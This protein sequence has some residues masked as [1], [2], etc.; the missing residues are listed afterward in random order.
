[1]S[2]DTSCKLLEDLKGFHKEKFRTINLMREMW[3]GNEKNIGREKAR[4][5]LA[6][7]LLK[8]QNEREKDHDK[9]LHLKY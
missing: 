4:K 6:F 5:I 9:I 3:H 1:M 7:S 2:K 8:Y